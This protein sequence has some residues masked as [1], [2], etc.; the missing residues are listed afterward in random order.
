MASYSFGL[1]GWEKTFDHAGGGVEVHVSATGA[2]FGPG[3]LYVRH[4]NGTGWYPH[5]AGSN[6]HTADFS[7]VFLTNQYR[8]TNIY[9]YNPDATTAIPVDVQVIQPR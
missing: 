4:Y 2:T 8:G 6:Y 1:Y 3:S 5:P 7:K 9:V